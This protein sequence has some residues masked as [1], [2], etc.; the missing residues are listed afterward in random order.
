M[1]CRW[2]KLFALATVMSWSGVSC[3]NLP[4][5]SH[6]SQSP[7]GL[8]AVPSSALPSIPICLGAMPSNWA[9]ALAGTTVAI[10]GVTG[11]GVQAVDPISNYAYGTYRASGNVR[12]AAINAKTGAV[13]VVAELPSTTA[14]IS[15]MSVADPWLVWVEQD[16]QSDIGVWKI[17]A[18]NRRTQA[19]IVLATNQ[20]PG[21]T[22]FP[23]F[24]TQPV[25]GPHYAAWVQPISDSTVELRVYQFDTKT[26][27]ALDRGMLSSPVLTGRYLAWGKLSSPGGKAILSLVDAST[28]SRVPTPPALATPR[29]LMF[30]T[31]SQYYLVWTPDGDSWIAQRLDDGAVKTFIPPS[32]GKHFAQYPMVAGTDLVWWSGLETTVVDLQTGNGFDFGGGSA[33]AS[34]DLLVVTGFQNGRETLSSATPSTIGSISSCSR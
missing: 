7:T 19:S 26:T 28:L 12:V 34:G 17:V 8:T 2:A 24:V 15:W 9:A 20:L 22:E 1:I 23:N 13:T 11:F 32:D 4:P 3:S 10:R 21:G 29:T 18:W 33:A 31:G 14:G 5:T 27:V 6:S 25:V 30:A 16:S